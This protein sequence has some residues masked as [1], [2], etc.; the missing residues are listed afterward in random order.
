MAQWESV[1]VRYGGSWA[2]FDY[3]GGD[4]QFVFIPTNPISLTSLFKSIN[5]IIQANVMSEEYLLYYLSHSRSGRM[6]KSLLTSDG[7]LQRLCTLERELIVYVVHKKNNDGVGSSQQA[8]RVPS[9]DEATRND[10]VGSS[11]QEP[12]IPSYDSSTPSSVFGYDPSLAD[13]ERFTYSDWFADP[14]TGSGAEM[15]SYRA[16]RQEPCPNSSPVP[17]TNYD[18]SNQY[19]SDKGDSE[20]EEEYQEEEDDE[21]EDEFDDDDE[22]DDGQTGLN[23]GTFVEFSSWIRREGGFNKL[24]SMLE[25]NNPPHLSHDQGYMECDGEIKNWLIPMIPLGESNSVIVS[26]LERIEEGVFRL[27][28]TFWN[29]DDMTCAVG[30]WHMERRREYKVSK[31]TTKYQWYNCLHADSCSFELRALWRETFWIVYQFKEIHTCNLEFGHLG[32]R[33]ISYKAIAAYF[34]KKMRNE[35]TMIK[36]RDIMEELLREFGI[37][38]S[39]DKAL[40]AINKAIEMIYGGYEASFKMLPRYLHVLKQYNPGTITKLEIGPDGRFQY[41]F[42]AFGVSR[43]AFLYHL[44]PVIVVD[45]THLKGKNKG[46]LF[47]AVT[48]DDNKQCFPLAVGVG[49]IENNDSW[50]WFLS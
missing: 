28:S 48:K 33:K 37:R 31:A 19:G 5:C 27:G 38:A 23:Y 25:Q 21:K 26:D 8:P 45:G 40:R 24:M 32:P 44:R 41:L 7:D 9:I 36:S 29:K 4:E 34:G 12:Y 20:E 30:L 42:V 14:W 1:I 17:T 3:I 2:N 43:T 49:P 13:I 18:M 11:Q 10:G 47:V 46:I 15:S 50:T 6:L 16:M 22:D 39:Y 35:G